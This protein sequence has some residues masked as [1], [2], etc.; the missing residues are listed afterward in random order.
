MSSTIDILHTYL[1][2]KKKIVFIRAAYCVVYFLVGLTMCSRG[3][4]YVLNLVDS[5]V[6]GYPFLGIGFCQMLAVPWAYG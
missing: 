3:G 2:S 4:L 5:A 1:N 6:G